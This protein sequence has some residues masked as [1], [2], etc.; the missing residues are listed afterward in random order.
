MA[1]LRTFIALDLGKPLRD[2]L[3]ALQQNLSRAGAGEVKWV[4]ANNLHLT[5]LF[6]GEV[7]ERDVPPLCR[8]VSD[9]AKTLPAF[10][11]VVAGTGCF[12]NSRRPRAPWGGGGGGGGPAG[13]LPAAPAT[14]R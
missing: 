5:L 2:R 11:L 3:V 4:E 13:A 10:P 8:A 14:P 7:D 9:V 1:R 6:L 12:P